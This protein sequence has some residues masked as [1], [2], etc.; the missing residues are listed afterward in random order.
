MKT[1]AWWTTRTATLTIQDLNRSKMNNRDNNK[2]A[3]TNTVFFTG[4]ASSTFFD[5]NNF[6]Q[7]FIRM[8][9]HAGQYWYRWNPWDAA[10]PK[11]LPA[12]VNTTRT[13][14]YSQMYTHFP[15]CEWSVPAGMWHPSRGS[16]SSC[17]WPSSCSNRGQAWVRRLK[18]SPA[19]RTLREESTYCYDLPAR[20]R[21]RIFRRYFTAGW[22]PIRRNSVLS[23]KKC[24]IALCTEYGL[25]DKE[26][27]LQ[28]YDF[29]FKNKRLILKCWQMRG[30]RVQPF[31]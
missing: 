29:N 31:L 4:A 21:N 3:T 10:N 13:R 27:L 16:W 25:E 6:D 19:V 11:L 22:I 26:C 7:W 2:G 8:M 20:T 24:S 15:Y 18:K 1:N 12:V 14:I 9:R 5:A 30:W 17:Y 28:N 23:Y